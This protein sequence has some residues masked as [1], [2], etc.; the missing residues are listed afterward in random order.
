MR[1]V[2]VLVL[3]LASG[4]A[5]YVL[6]LRSGERG[7]LA[8]LG[9]GPPA[10]ARTRSS[11]RAAPSLLEDEVEQ[12]SGIPGT[13]ADAPI[14][15]APAAT[16][17]A[18]TGYTYLRVATSGPSVRER[19]QGFVWLIVLVSVSA[20]LLALAAYQTGHFI[21]QTMKHFLK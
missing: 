10:P 21:N 16:A 13:V 20:A 18:G 17:R 6:T 5:V 15:E 2:F 11:E 19:L 4:G 3:S 9:F 14:A 7:Q 8:G 12:P 1:Y